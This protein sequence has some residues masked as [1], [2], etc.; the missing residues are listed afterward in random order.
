MKLSRIK[1]INQKIYELD[2]DINRYSKLIFISTLIFCSLNEKFRDPSK[3]S[4][5]INFMGSDNPINDLI[6]LAKEEIDKLHLNENVLNSVNESLNLISGVSTKLY[7][8]RV[9]LKDFVLDFVGDVIPLLAEDDTPFLELLYME[10]DKKAKNSDKGITLT[11]AF[12]AGLMIKLIDLDY[13][14]DVV[15]DLGC[16]TGLFSLMAYSYMLKAL[17]KDKKNLSDDEYTNYKNRLLN[18]V[19]ANDYEPKMVT[20]CL[21]NFILKGLNSNLIRKEDV[22]KFEKNNFNYHDENNNLITIKPNK[23]ILNPPYED[24]YKPVEFVRKT[25]EL[26]KS[27]EKIEQKVV[28]IIPP[29]KFGLKREELFKILNLSRLES[30]VVMQ[31]D[32]FCESGQNPS[33]SIFVFNLDRP[34]KKDDVI[35]YFDFKDSGYVYV[36]DSGMVDKNGVFNDRVNALFEDMR[37]RKSELNKT[38][39]VRSLNNFYELDAGYNSIKIDPNVVRFNKEEADITYQNTIIRRGLTEKKKLIKDNN[40]EFKDS[41]GSFEDY[42]VSLISED[43]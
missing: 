6:K 20:L 18:S 19:V 25:I 24:T 21:A 34:H 42:L 16:G 39:F 17:E 32:L 12:A 36:K 5:V 1:G 33:T 43:L 7:M 10:V 11:P 15:A 40:E 29:Q 23:A 27:T 38:T 31:D 8:N 35:Q 14:K 9:A 28:V 3:T 37:T 4:S 13:K 30:V 2:T 41:D 22:F 26:V